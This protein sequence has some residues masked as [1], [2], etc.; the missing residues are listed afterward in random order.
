MP[1]RAELSAARLRRADAV[2]VKSEFHRRAVIE[3]APGV[4]GRCIVVPNGVD[5]TEIAE[6][7]AEIAA[8]IAAEA[9]N[10][11]PTAELVYSSSYDRGLEEQLRHGWPLIHAALPHARLHVYYGWAT[12]VA[13][14]PRSAWLGLGFG[15]GLGFGLGLE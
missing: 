1:L 3:A 5:E 7:K 4:A 15:F 6:I 12:H 13:M 10:P 2:M 9:R 11:T 8:E 14:H